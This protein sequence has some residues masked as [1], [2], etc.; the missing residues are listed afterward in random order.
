MDL[1]KD[2]HATASRAL[3]GQ[4]A[5]WQ[6][7]LGEAAPWVRDVN[8]NPSLTLDEERVTCQS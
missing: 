6:L 8:R 1:H 4:F 3:S 7:A 2:L 5:N